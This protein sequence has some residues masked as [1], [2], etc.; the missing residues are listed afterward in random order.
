MPWALSQDKNKRDGNME[1][2]AATQSGQQARLPD[3]QLR[4]AGHWQT[5]ET[6]P[7][8]WGCAGLLQSASSPKRGSDIPS[9]PVFLPLSGIVTACCL[10]AFGRLITAG[11]TVTR[12]GTSQPTCFGRG[13]TVVGQSVRVLPGNL[14][15]DAARLVGKGQRSLSVGAEPL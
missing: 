12:T 8:A 13:P 11:A 15:R 1:P 4:S 14:R 7:K 2:C 5:R 10:M 6:K 9:G 3:R